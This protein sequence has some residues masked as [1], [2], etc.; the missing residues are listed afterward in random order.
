LLIPMQY[1]AIV[2]DAYY[3]L[4]TSTCVRDINFM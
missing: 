3:Q 4:L 1:D 2:S